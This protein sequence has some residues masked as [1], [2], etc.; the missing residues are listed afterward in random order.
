MIS[1]FVKAN[2]KARRNKRTNGS[3]YIFIKVPSKSELQCKKAVYLFIFNY[4]FW[5]ISIL[6]GNFDTFSKKRNEN[7][8]NINLTVKKSTCNHKV[9]FFILN[10]SYSPM[11]LTLERQKCQWNTLLVFHL[12]WH[13]WLRT[14]GWG[15]T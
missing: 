6:L 15:C 14:W 2:V 4:R 8:K 13:C 3:I 9:S 10:L 11:V 1:G 12:A 7:I 5:L